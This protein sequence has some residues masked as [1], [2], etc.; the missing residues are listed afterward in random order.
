[1]ASVS[2]RI[3]PNDVARFFAVAGAQ[4]LSIFP[5]RDTDALRRVIAMP[6]KAQKR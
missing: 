4:G 3:N 1:M 2:N 5:F 6:A